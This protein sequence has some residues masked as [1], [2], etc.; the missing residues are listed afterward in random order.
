MI[1]KAIGT[2]IVCGAVIGFVASNW[3]DRVLFLWIVGFIGC[4]QLV[5]QVYAWQFIWST[6]AAL[7]FSLTAGLIRVLFFDG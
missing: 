2:E 7:P 5:W 1:I 4:V 6:I 3:S